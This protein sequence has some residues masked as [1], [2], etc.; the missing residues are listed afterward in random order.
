METNTILV[1][2]FAAITL[3]LLVGGQ[4][5][6]SSRVPFWLAAICTASAAAA[7]HYDSFWTMFCFG[8]IGA[9]AFIAGLKLLDT[10]WRMRAGL[11]FAVSALGLVSI[12]PSVSSMT[13]GLVPCPQYIAERVTFRLVAGLDLR[14]GLRLVYTVDVDEALKDRRDRHYDDMQIALA[15]IFELHSGD[16]R[17]S[18]EVYVKLRERVTMEKPP[19]DARSVR[20]TIKDP[21]DAAKVDA[22]FLQ[23]FAAEMAYS[24]SDQQ[25]YVFRLRN[26]VE[27]Q[28]RENAVAQAKEIVLRRV[29]EL[30][31]REA[32][33]STRDEDIIVEVPGQDEAGFKEIR[34]IIG[35]TARLEFKLLDDDTDFF[36]S[37]RG[38]A[39]RTSL[40]EGV[41]FQ[42]ETASVGQDPEGELKRKVN[43]FAEMRKKPEETSKQALDRFKEWAAT[44]TLPPD[45]ELGFEMAYDQDP[46]TGKS[47]EVG[48]RT[49]LLKSRAEITGDMI[50]DAQAQ[51]DSSQ[52]SLGGWYVAIRF[53]DAG[54]AIFERITGANIK[55]R[56]AIIL[57]GRIESAP[58]IQSRIAGGNASITLGAGDAESQLRDA[59]KLEL[60][61]RSGALPAPITPSNEQ[62]IGPSLG[63]DSIQL[64]VR[65]AM[66]G[67]I[68]VLAFMV[69]YYRQ[70]GI[71]ANIAVTFNIVLLLA[72]LASF[73]AS[74]TLPGIAGLA[75]TVG[76]SVDANVLINE[77]IRDELR[78]GRSPRASVDLGYSKAFS[79][80][81]DGHLT[82]L[83]S[84]IVL[85]QFGTGPIKGFAVT[86]IVGVA[87][88][89]FTGVTMTRVMFDVWVRGL[90]RNAKLDLG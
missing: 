40:P 90:R 52:N 29:D 18:E 55:R 79:A 65:G 16:E 9:W 72:I 10:S 57:D 17:P 35:Q 61:L 60:V 53:T 6:R 37:F 46:V 22:P 66:V 15:K 87:C 31:L 23:Q 81:V 48:W 36:A 86:L 13:G 12:W 67:V 7:A 33:V 85:A 89:L 3:A 47:S 62:H 70:S 84:G 75:L 14:G 2:V 38:S 26:T 83:T 28:I 51:P 56:F 74:M 77:R 30:G 49:Y 8:T 11:V 78:G 1:F 88:S 43:T 19:G 39:E 64:G 68:L 50:R 4:L 45:R 21:A 58:V 42:Q 73:G 24:A 41:G 76:M 54:G 44:L 63:A 27:S 69:T 20:L 71:F 5:R 59:R 34:D 80:I 82:T 25:G 32:A